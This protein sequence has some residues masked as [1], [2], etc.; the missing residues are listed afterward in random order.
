MPAPG[1]D[2]A[3]SAESDRPD[4]VLL[5]GLGDSTRFWA[6]LLPD[7]GARYRVHA[8]DLPGHGTAARPLTAAEAAPGA[9]ARSVVDGL[10]RAGVVAPHLVGFS[11]G[12]WVALEMAAAGYGRSVVALAPVGLWPTPPVVSNRWIRRARG[13][14]LG[15]LDPL[16]PALVRWPRLARVAVRGTVVDPAKVTSEQLLYSARDRRR[17][18]GAS[19]VRRAVWASRFAD[20]AKISVPVCVAFGDADRVVRPPRATEHDVLPESARWVSVPHCGHAMSWDQPEACL[21]LIAETSARS[22]A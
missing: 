15:L 9:L 19:A 12:G 21:A 7:L 6:N 13:V 5:H 18:L 17:A 10:R 1:P 16:L 2:P 14:A 8:V 22:S 11:L 4:L 3:P 20:G